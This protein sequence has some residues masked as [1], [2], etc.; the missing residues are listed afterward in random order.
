MQVKAN[1]T[2]L[3]FKSLA[4]WAGGFLAYTQLRDRRSQLQHE[5]IHEQSTTRSLQAAY[6]RSTL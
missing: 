1:E 2:F 5:V 3:N 6:G 4:G